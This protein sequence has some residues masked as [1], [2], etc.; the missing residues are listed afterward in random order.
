M[1]K[2]LPSGRPLIYWGKLEQGETGFLPFVVG[3]QISRFVA[4]N[5]SVGS[6][7][8]SQNSEENGFE[9]LDFATVFINRWFLKGADGIH[10][11]VSFPVLTSCISDLLENFSIRKGF[12]PED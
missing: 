11:L 12:G 4:L 1:F 6:I 3:C 5:K 7:L 2:C 10:V 8:G 9:G